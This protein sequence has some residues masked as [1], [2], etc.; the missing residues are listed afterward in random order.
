MIY[1]DKDYVAM[2]DKPFTE[3][4]VCAFFGGALDGKTMTVGELLKSGMVRGKN[5]DNSKLRKSCA[6]APYAIFDNAP[7]VKGY[8]GPMGGSPEAPLRYESQKVY[9][10]LSM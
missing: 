2:M 9:D 7:L 3:D 6:Y 1:G 10:A 5:A 4:T 8:L